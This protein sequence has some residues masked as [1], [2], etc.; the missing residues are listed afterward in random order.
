MSD[1]NRVLSRAGARELTQE[2]VE[3]VKGA[4]G[5]LVCTGDPNTPSA[6]GDGCR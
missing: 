4:F 6:D 2:E 5:T 3:S 1:S